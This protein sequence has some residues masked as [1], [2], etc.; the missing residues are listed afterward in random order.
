MGL[1]KRLKAAWAVLLG[2]DMPET[3]HINL[4][5]DGKLIFTTTTPLHHQSQV[6]FGL[7]V[8][9]WLS[10]DKRVM[11]VCGLGDVKLFAVHNP[12]CGTTDCGDGVTMPSPRPA[13]YQG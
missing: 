13:R 10:G 5:G 11:I 9:A 7:A 3:T 1:L 6:A 4:G 12:R 2:R 8:E